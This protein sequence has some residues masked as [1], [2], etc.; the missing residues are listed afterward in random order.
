MI[1][2]DNRKDISPQKNNKWLHILGWVLIIFG[3]FGLLDVGYRLSYGHFMEGEAFQ[4]IFY[5]ILGLIF[6]FGRTKKIK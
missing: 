3:L 4:N 2:E 5:L 6:V 1:N